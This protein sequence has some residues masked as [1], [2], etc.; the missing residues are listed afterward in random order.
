MLY[1]FRFIWRWIIVTLKSG[2]G[3]TEGHLSWYY[4]KAWVWFAIHFHSNYGSI[5]HHFRDK[6]RY[7]S[8]RD[9]FI[10]PCIRCPHKGGPRRNIAIPFGMEKLEWWGYLTVENFENMYNR[11]DKIP[12]W[13]RQTDGRTD[14][15]SD[16]QTDGQ[17]SFHGI[18]RAMHTCSAVKTLI[19]SLVPY[20]VT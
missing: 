17:T 1:H 11:L 15:Q 10:P 7:W 16:R 20:Y 8:K 2:L 5:L 13:D 12:E 4:S 14:R 19:S 3:F 6:A 9:F 18:V